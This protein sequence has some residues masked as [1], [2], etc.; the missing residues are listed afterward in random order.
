MTQA[1]NLS[2]L[3]NN[4]N[5]SGL[6]NAAAGLYNSTPVPNGGTGVATVA[7]GS[8]LVGAGTAA[9]T[10]STS[11]SGT[12]LGNKIQPITATVA[13]SALT[14]QL[15]PATLDF[16]S[17]TLGS[18]TV[19]SR[20]VAAAITVV[21]PSTATLG[22]TSAVASRLILLAIDNAGTIEL[23]VI[24]IAG[25]TNIN[26]TT[27]ISTTAVSA[28]ATSASV[29][30]STTARTSLPFRV[31]GYIDSTQAT[32]GTWATAPS[33]IQGAGGQ[34]AI[35]IAMNSAGSAP[36]YACR[37]WVNFNGTGTVAIRASGNVS[38]IT[39]NGVGNYTMNLTTATSDANY[40]FS[41]T[42]GD[43]GVAFGF[44]PLATSVPTSS[45]LR[46]AVFAYNGA[47]NTDMPYVTASITR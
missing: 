38:S 2:Q 27:L 35:P 8:I 15:N 14:L 9:M 24:N 39:D 40:H 29:A 32:A 4:V 43:P 20:T 10:T 25:G 42:A 11:V 16:R 46:F 7:T 28:A 19:N 34:S 31:V 18:G 17:P 26:E 3:A 23:A 22:T 13:T 44:A 6:L 1:F 41:I 12:L 5:S 30:Y 45:A 36:M 47:I 33:T 21:V 37:A